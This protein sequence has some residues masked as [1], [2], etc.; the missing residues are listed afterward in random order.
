M[1]PSVYDLWSE[2]EVTTEI[3]ITCFLPN[4]IVIPLKC[5]RDATITSIKRDL[6]KLAETYPLYGS[7]LDLNYYIFQCINQSAE[8]EELLDGNRKLCDVKPFWP[9]LR[10]IRKASDVEE[11]VLNSKIGLLIGKSLHEWDMMK[12][13]EVDDF[14]RNNRRMCMTIQR[15]RASWEWERKAL[16][17]YP[18]QVSASSELPEHIS[19]IFKRNNSAFYADIT[20][21]SS[22]AKQKSV[23]PVSCHDYPSD[24]IKRAVRKVHQQGIAEDQYVIKVRGREDFLMGNYPLSQFIYIRQCVSKDIRP[25]LLLLQKSEMKVEEMFIDP[26]L[27]ALLQKEEESPVIPAKKGK[28][29]SWDIH[30]EKIRVTFHGAFNVNF[31]EK[32]GL[33]VRA[34]VYHGGEELC[35]KFFSKEAEAPDPVWNEEFCADIEVSNLPRMARLCILICSLNKKLAKNLSEKEKAKRLKYQKKE[36]IPLAWVNTTFFNYQNNLQAGRIKFYM[37]PAS[38]DVDLNPLGCVGSNPNHEDTTMIEVSFSTYKAAQR[39]TVSYPPFDTVLERA[40]M[41]AKKEERNFTHESI[42]D[43]K[44]EQLRNMVE[45]EPLE[46]L[47]EQENEHLWAARQDCRDHIPHSLPRLLTC[48]RWS[49]K[50]CVAQMQALLQIWPELKPEEAM[51]LLDYRYPDLSVRKFAVECLSNLHD[52]QLS[53]YLLQLVQALKY[54]THLDCE[55]GQ[56]LLRRALANQRIGHFLFWHLR[57]EMHQAA[58]TT[59]FGLMLEAYCRGSIAHMAALIRQVESLNKMR[60]VNELIKTKQAKSQ[61]N[62][63]LLTNMREILNQESY[64]EAMSNFLSPLSPSYKLKGLRLKKCKFIS[65]KMRPLW[66]VF[67]NNDPMGD[68]IYIIFKNGDDLRQDM[69]TLQVMQIMDNIWQEEGLDLRL[70]PYKTLATGNKVGMIQVVTEAETIAKIQKEH[71]GATKFSAAFRKGALFEWLKKQNPT[72]A[73]FTHAIEDFTLSC[74][75]YCVATYVLGIGDRHNDNIMIKKTGQLFHIDFGHFLGNYKRKFGFKRER[76][77]F[78]LVHDFVHVITRGKG[79][80]TTTEFETFRKCCED[81]FMILR[82]RGNLLINLFAMMLSSGIPELSDETIKYLRDT[83][84]LDRSDDEALK[85]FKGKFNEALKNSWKTSID[86]MAHIIAHARD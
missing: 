28:T 18:P 22:K 67:E 41:I 56:F 62:F 9:M 35:E 21:V 13:P 44:L 3:E 6:W 2:E 29:L 34:G 81:A 49:D 86:W 1:P 30:K 36:L 46:P 73:Q 55:L 68:D 52:S 15:Q 47:S 7:L 59:R 64:H 24:L 33:R 5:K 60:T 12:N 14:R 74:A 31:V 77:P 11:K 26:M 75:G 16:Y 82:Q 80:N 63:D 78:V 37:W 71:I 40:A 54:E 83:L 53:Q 66:L 20:F 42:N 76:V 43:Q 32:A 61:T 23:L 25:E 10:V 48:V 38:E 69:L 79:N 70:I 45:K 65:S 27:N 50:D 72:E 39:G 17:L 51:E 19:K 84:V 85:H 57:A 8:Q 58:V 4:S